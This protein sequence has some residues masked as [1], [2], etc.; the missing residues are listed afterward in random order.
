MKERLFIKD[1]KKYVQIEELLMK[2]FSNSMC[3]GI[4]IHDTPMGTSIVIHTTAP[5]L[6]IGSG[7]EKIKAITQIVKERFGLKNPQIDV[8][9]IKRPD[10]NPDIVAQN[11]VR[12]LE[13]GMNYKRVGNIYLSRVMKSGARGCEIII[14][15]KLG[16]EKARKER[17]YDGFIEKSGTMDSVLKGFAVATP[18][19][20]NIGVK[21]YIMLKQEG[22]QQE[23]Q[24][25]E[26]EPSEETVKETSE[27]MAEQDE[28][29]EK[30]QET[31]KKADAEEIAGENKEDEPSAAEEKKG[32]PEKN[33]EPAENESDD[34]EN[35]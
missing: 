32:K 5:G 2:E 31:V 35:E 7:G 16:G 14:A 30:K 19:L 13:S 29:Q 26:E 3:G 28:E 9:K 8:Q 23:E 20:G 12:A 34:A 27:D 1:S 33:A 18:K 25:A 6:V 10:L 4:E 17:F 11:I 21:V 24:A 15:G 22:E